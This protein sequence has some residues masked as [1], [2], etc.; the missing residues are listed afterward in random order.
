MKWISSYFFSRFLSAFLPLLALAKMARPKVDIVVFGATGFTGKYVVE[1]CSKFENFTWAVAG[2]NAG[3]IRQLLDKISL[4]CGS[5]FAN[6]IIYK[7]NTRADIKPGFLKGWKSSGN[8]LTDVAIIEANCDDPDSLRK[9]AAVAELVINCTGPYRFYGENVVKAC[10]EAGTNYIDITGEP[11]VSFADR[12]CKPP[13]KK[14]RLNYF[15]R[16][17]TIVYGT[18]ATRVPR[19]SGEERMLRYQL[20]RNG[21]GT[22]GRRNRP[23]C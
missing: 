12:K 2:R 18:N 9:M 6:P 13:P 14:D 4:K 19:F 16:T 7:Y 21:F 11:E 10:V 8:D 22:G 23:F 3:K 17:Y 1:E 5:C 20:V 15:T